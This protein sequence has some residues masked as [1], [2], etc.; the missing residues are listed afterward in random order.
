M[1]KEFIE[2]IDRYDLAL[3]LK[4]LGFNHKT[5]HYITPDNTI[6]EG[7]TFN[8]DKRPFNF[9]SAPTYQRIFNW[10]EVE[11][12]IFIDRVTILTVN[13]ILGFDYELKSIYGCVCVVINNYDDFDVNK[14]NPILVEALLDFVENRFI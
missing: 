13:E 12:G 5:S 10:F 8:S 7:I 6:N 14:V 1:K 2:T 9:C 3:K 4:G 11:Y